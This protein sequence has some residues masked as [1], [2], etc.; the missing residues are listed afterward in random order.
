M[1]LP[2]NYTESQ[3]EARAD[4]RIEAREYLTKAWDTL[5]ELTGDVEAT[6]EEL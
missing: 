4:K 2:D 5:Y 1:S 3:A 6:F